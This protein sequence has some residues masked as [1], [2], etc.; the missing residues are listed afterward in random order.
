MKTLEQL[1]QTAQ[2]ITNIRPA[3]REIL[4]FYKEVFRVQEESLKDIQLPPIMIEPDLLMLAAEEL[5]AAPRPF[6]SGKGSPR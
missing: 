3:Y 1:C 5:A 2:T 4:D 6:R